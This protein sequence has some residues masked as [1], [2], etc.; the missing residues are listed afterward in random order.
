VE[1]FSDAT[2]HLASDL[3][4]GWP[5]MITVEETTFVQYTTLR[6]QINHGLHIVIAV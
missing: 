1:V 4:A 5:D 2:R 3:H 6:L